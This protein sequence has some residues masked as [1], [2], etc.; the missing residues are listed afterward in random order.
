MRQILSHYNSYAKIILF[1]NPQLRENRK[2]QTFTASFGNNA[3]SDKHRTK[4]MER[5][6]N[7]YRM[8]IQ[9]SKNGYTKDIQPLILC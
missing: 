9:L 1:I 7:G 3:V 4:D 6:Y 2:T 8:V 5:I